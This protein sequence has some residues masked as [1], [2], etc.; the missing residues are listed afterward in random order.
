[1]PIDTQDLDQH[2]HALTRS[3]QLPGVSYA[4]LRG[5]DEVAAGVFGL[6]DREA[7]RPM[8]RDTIVRAYSNTKL[9]T[10]LAVLRLHDA[11]LFGLDDPVAEWIPALR[12]LRVLRPGA[13]TLDDTVP[14]AT[15]VTVRH[16]LTHTAGFGQGLFDA[17]T[18]LQA[19]YWQ[20]GV[21]G[22]D[23]TL[24]ELMEVFG[25]LPLN[26][27]PGSAWDYSAATDV[28]ARL[29]EV[30]SGQR[31]GDHLQ[32][33]VFGPLGMVDTAH[34]LARDDQRARLAALYGV[35]QGLEAGDPAAPATRLLTDSPYPGAFLVPKPRQ[36]GAGGLV[37]TLPDWLALMRALLPGGPALLRPATREQA[38]RDQLAPPLS[39][40]FRRQG[41]F[42]GPM[43][44]LGFGLLG[45]VTRAASATTPAGSEGVVQWGG[46][47]GTHW[48]IDPLRG[49]AGALMTQRMMGFWQP[50]WFEAQ[51]LM[52]AAMG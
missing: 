19:A 51:R 36:G 49:T 47:A 38:L 17:G 8:G 40:Q 20:R 23:T 31:F 42:G 26:A 39:V 9:V 30:V 15:P 27:Q 12:G 52:F 33:Q 24:A 6:A 13:Q 7:G 5:Q 11:G 41:S 4:L 16:L 2:L 46:L 32:Q 34:V 48:W 22:A 37:T 35:P 25:T 43:P 29:V 21:R 10:S 18:L 50:W 44:A 3:G 28:A 45:A 1:M 14:L